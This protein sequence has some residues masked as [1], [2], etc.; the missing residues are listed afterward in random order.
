MHVVIPLPDPANAAEDE[1]VVMRAVMQ[2]VAG[3]M[4][5][6]HEQHYYPA[7]ASNSYSGFGSTGTGLVQFVC[8]I[9][10]QSLNQKLVN[11]ELRQKVKEMADKHA[12]EEGMEV[13]RLLS[14]NCTG[15]QKNQSGSPFYSG[16][17]SRNKLTSASYNPIPYQ[18]TFSASYEVVPLKPS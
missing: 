7:G 17:N 13:K 18:V 16:S 5:A 10:Q 4:D 9:N 14:T 3:V 12:A 1:I 2:R 6:L 8:K 11:S 15:S